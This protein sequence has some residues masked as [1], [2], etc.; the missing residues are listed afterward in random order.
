MIHQFRD[1][2][3][4]NKNKKIIKYIILFILFFIILNFGLLDFLGNVFN[5][6][7]RPIWNAEKALVNE[8][9]DSGHLWQSKK[10]IFQQNAQL[11]EENF[12]FKNL[13]INYSILEKENIQLKEILGRLA[14]PNDYI[15]ANILAKPNSS[16]Y[17][18]LIIDIGSKNE[19]LDNNQVFAS[20]D[21]PIGYI[22]R[23]YENTSVVSLFTN[24]GQET[25]GFIEDSNVSITLTGRGG[26]NFE[27]LVPIELSIGKGTIIYLPAQKPLVVAL[28]EEIISSPSDPYKKVILS[29]PV[30]VQ[31]LKW[32][33]IKKK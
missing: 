11:K 27:M 7:G 5:Y 1:K 28:V 33:Q 6:I 13:L 19:V 23:V 16:P 3:R 31:N 29:S 22:S 15:L 26:G 2:K 8:I 9:D 17:D 21:I 30:N 24:P 4:I 32:V 14:S 18:T 20:G 10:S 12:Y 25:E